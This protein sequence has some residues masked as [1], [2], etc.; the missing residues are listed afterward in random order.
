MCFFLLYL[1]CNSDTL[2]RFTGA[3]VKSILATSRQ[4]TQRN[5]CMYTDLFAI[6]KISERNAKREMASSDEVKSQQVLFCCR[7]DNCEQT[8]GTDFSDLHRN[9][10]VCRFHL[11]ILS[12][13]YFVRS[14]LIVCITPHT[15]NYRKPCFRVLKA[16]LCTTQ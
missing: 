11:L 14:V 5:C 7:V 15:P 4:T 13:M 2:D 12:G 9:C 16:V 1:N 10:F 6:Y 8:S 3:P